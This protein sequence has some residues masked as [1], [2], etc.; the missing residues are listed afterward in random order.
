M[1]E[2]KKIIDVSAWTGRW[3][4]I[5]HRFAELPALR[6]KLESVNIKKVFLAPIEAVLEQ[7]PTRANAELFGMVKDGFFSPVPVIDLSYGNWEE[8]FKRFTGDERV[9]MVKLIPNYHRYSLLCPETDEFI[10]LVQER[11]LIIS[12][13]VKV[14]D[15]RSHYPLMKVP[16]VPRAEVVQALGK[17]PE[18]EF[19]IHCLT[20]SDVKGYMD[21]LKNIYLDIACL[22]T[23]DSLAYMQE[24]YTLDRILFASHCPFYFVEGN[25]N[26]L[27]Y[28]ALDD[29]EVD[30][31][32]YRNAERLFG[33]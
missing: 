4:F 10:K 11:K 7:D 30:K 13:Q 2:V 20:V 33:L 17:Y 15:P 14:E 22:E 29:D 6:E 19:I 23:R 1:R 21:G 26:K 12:V 16:N 27:T 28:S 24:Y 3:P 25:I 18:Q 32:A 31:V 9:K 8:C 5:R